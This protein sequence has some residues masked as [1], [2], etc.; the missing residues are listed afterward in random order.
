MF[1][2]AV[3]EKYLCLKI[4]RQVRVM[5]GGKYGSGDRTG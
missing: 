3:V 5:S 2:I 1:S 4:A